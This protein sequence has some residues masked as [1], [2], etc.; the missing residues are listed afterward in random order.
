MAETLH[1]SETLRVRIFV[2]FWNFNLSIR[3]IEKDFKID[4]SPI[5]KLFAAQAGAL[6]N[7]SARTVFEA[8]H[9]YGSIDF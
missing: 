8:M 4:W 5:G 2:D 9:V 1:L 7:P 6:I 3:Q